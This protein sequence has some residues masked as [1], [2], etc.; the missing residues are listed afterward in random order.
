MK[1]RQLFEAKASS[2][3]IIFGRFNPPHQG[4]RAAWEMASEND[5][6]F[7]GTNKSTEG[8]KDPL[9]YEVKV[10]AM[11][12][13]Y[14]EIEGHIVAEQ[15][16]LTLASKVYRKYGNAVL[17]IYTDE[18]WVTKALN[19]YNGQEGPHG[20]YNFKQIDQKKIVN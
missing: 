14:P 16:W 4:H 5:V 20:F 3:G 11:K 10:E 7:V 6:W 19:Q 9:P 17:N 8:P 13:V 1:L 12:A 15:S 2:V 18:E